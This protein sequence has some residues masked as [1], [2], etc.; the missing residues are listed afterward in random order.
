MRPH[1]TVLF[2]L[3]ACAGAGC[4]TQPGDPNAR[5]RSG[6]D[7]AQISDGGGL[8]GRG[9]DAAAPDGGGAVADGVA[10]RGDAGVDA[11]VDVAAL[12]DGA[13]PDGTAGADAPVGAPDGAPLADGGAVDVAGD[14][15]GDVGGDAA[16]G[17]ADAPEV[18]IDTGPAGGGA[19]GGG[20]VDAGSD[21]DGLG[22]D[23]AD[24]A[25]ADTSG[26]P[27]TADAADGAGE[28]DT[29]GEVCAPVAPTVCPDPQPTFA[30][31]QPVFLTHCAVCHD[32]AP[33][34]PWPLESYWHI[35]AWKTEI[36]TELLDCVM[37]P[38]ESETGFTEADRALILTWIF[39]GAPK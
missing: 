12:T 18:A 29:G 13:Q 1:P 23:A 19:D 3:G 15:G 11:G 35:A 14:A 38:E 25:D 28:A 4:L 39:C 6:G 32:A 16:G 2:I 27:D 34:G 7:T 26:A 24:G 33:G 30:D 8:A 5:H 17:A 36:R 31:V 20:P 21:L 22:V 37:P 9:G 10:L